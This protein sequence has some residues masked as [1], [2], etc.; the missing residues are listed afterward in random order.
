MNVDKA[1]LAFAGFV[2]LLGLAL[3]TY[4]NEY[5]Y[6]LTAFAG[7]NM[8]QASFTGFC[9]AAIVFKKLGLNSGCAFS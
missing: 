7:L 9:P 5:W 3:G 2:V 4:V 6:L 1:V 8:L